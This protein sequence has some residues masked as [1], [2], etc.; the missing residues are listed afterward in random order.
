M[1]V[2]AETAVGR[3]AQSGDGQRL[4][5]R[6][7]HLIGTDRGRPRRAD[8]TAE[9][10]RSDG[11]G[12]AIDRRRRMARRRA[13]N[14]RR[15]ARGRRAGA[16]AGKRK[17]RQQQAARRQT[18]CQVVGWSPCGGGGGGPSSHCAQDGAAAASRTARARLRRRIIGASKAFS[19]SQP[20]EEVDQ[21]FVDLGRPLLL[22]PMAGALEDMAAAQAGQGLGVGVELGLGRREAQ[23]A[24]AAA[25]DEQ[26]RLA[27]RLAAPRPAELPV[28]PEVAVPVQAAAKAGAREFLGVVVEIGLAQPRRQ[29]SADRRC[30][31]ASVP[32]VRRAKPLPFSVSSPPAVK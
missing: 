4:H 25:G 30:W 17:R 7:L 31:R 11:D 22:H 14:H 29:V 1:A 15:I 24:V 13:G 10:D 27:D 26:R 32:P 6:L 12:I 9:R 21:Q 28:A 5:Q 3:L 20:L 19:G 16:D 2:E 8:V 23:H 18:A